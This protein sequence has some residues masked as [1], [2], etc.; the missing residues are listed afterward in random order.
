MFGM[1]FAPR[2]EVRF[3]SDDN[4]CAAWHYPGTNG[5]CVVMAGGTGVTKEPG[6]DRFAAAFQ[7]AGLDPRAVRVTPWLRRERF[8]GFL[9]DMDL[10]LDCP[11]FS[12][13]TTAWQAV[14]RGLPIVTLEGEFLRQRLAAGLLRQIGLP[15][16]IA[17]S[18]E[19]YLE[20][21]SSWSREVRD[22]R[23]WALRRETLRSAAGKADGNRG[24]VSALQQVLTEALQGG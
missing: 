16:G 19:Q 14:H 5:A 6:T 12:G 3:P 20:R 13:Y 17:Q 24:A 23:A 4:Y 8:M 11:A 22:T 18:P 1:T 7:A 15:E 2:T 21:T 9:D 10:Y